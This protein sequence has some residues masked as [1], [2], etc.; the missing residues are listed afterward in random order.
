[1]L[2]DKIFKVIWKLLNEWIHI[3]L[4]GVKREVETLYRLQIC[5]V[6]TEMVGG[7]ASLILQ[8]I[9]EI[10]VNGP[11]LSVTKRC[12]HSCIRP[13]HECHDALGGSLF[14]DLRLEVAAGG[15][16]I[17]SS[18]S[19]SWKHIGSFWL[20]RWALL[21]ESG[22]KSLPSLPPQALFPSWLP[23]T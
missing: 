14:P 12:E 11:Q 23:Y 3:K 10:H 1:M 9:A 6:R 15:R 21:R 20:V 22:S 19:M 13:K 7:L 18:G 5:Y 17:R 4:K 2:K 16:G 8:L